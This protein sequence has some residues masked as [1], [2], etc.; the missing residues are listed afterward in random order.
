[1]KVKKYVASLVAT[2][3]VAWC[4]F[5]TSS[6]AARTNPKITVGKTVSYTSSE[7]QTV[8]A[9]EAMSLVLN[10]GQ[11]D[12]SN[13]VTFNFRLPSNARVTEVKVAAPLYKHF[14]LGAIL[15]ERLKVTDPD[16]DTQEV[17]WGRGNVTDISTFISKQAAGTWSVSYYG[18]NLAFSSSGMRFIGAVEY[19]PVTMTIN[20]VLE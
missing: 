13:T 3:V 16:G 14:G 6:Y 2:L 15:A 11:S 10:P 5:P 12:Y 19:K 1:M 8:T 18:T 7:S 17:P 20:Y 9:A 4:V